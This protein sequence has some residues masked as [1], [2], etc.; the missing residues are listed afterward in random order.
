MDLGLKGKRALVTGASQGIGRACAEALAREGCHLE[1]VARNAETLEA[2]RRELEK[3]YGVQVKSHPLDLAERG[4]AARLAQECAGVDILVNNAGSTPRGTLLELDEESWRQGWELKIFGYINLTREL[5]RR[6]V[7]RRAGVIV[8]VIGIGAEKLEYAY[9][10][11]STGN[12][13]LV[14]LTRA[15]GSVSLDYG[16]RVLGVSP[17]WVETEKSK[18]GLRRRAQVELGDA[19]RWPELTR[20]WPRGFLIRPQEIG[21]VVAFTA[22]ERAGAMSGVIVTVDAGFSA[23]GYPY[24]VETRPA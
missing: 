5:Y 22:S 19:E 10:A 1:L 6:M 20:H 18:R 14:A 4:T 9:A 15:I 23:R 11:G 24:D 17:G 3:S 2:A 21:D 12:A 13:A 8:N 7:E 16:V